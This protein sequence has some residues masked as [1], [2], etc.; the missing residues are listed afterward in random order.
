MTAFLRRAGTARLADGATL[1]WSLADGSRG[2]RW[3]AVATRD[4][5]ITHSL[6]LEVDLD[7]R[8]ARLELTTP[9]GT[10]D[11]SSRR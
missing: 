11:A 8:P 3:R 4:G 2:R 5:S 10:P 6:L 7:G 9:D 1:T